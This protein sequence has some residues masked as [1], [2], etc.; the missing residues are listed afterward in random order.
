MAKKYL[1]YD[2][3]SHFW[4]EI[5]G[6]FALVSHTHTKSEITDFPT[7]MTPSSHTH[8]NITNGG[9]L[10]SDVTIATGDKLTIVDSSNSSKIAR[11]SLSFDTA[12]S[13]TDKKALTQAG[14]WQT[15]L[16]SADV[17]E[18]ASA[19]STTPKM[20]GTATVGTET[21][22]ARG[23]HI[24]PTDTSRAASSHT[25]GNITNAGALQTTDVAIANG[26][27]LVVTDASNSNKVARTSVSF[28]GS[29]ATQ[30][31]SK[32]GTWVNVGEANVLEGV[33]IIG[34]DLTIT[35]K[36]VN[37]PRVSFDNDG[38]LPA[39][40]GQTA[41]GNYVLFANVSSGNITASCGVLGVGSSY[42]STGVSINL[43]QDNI[44]TGNLASISSAT[45]SNAGV[46]SATD[47]SKLDSI[48]MTNGVIDSS[49]LPSFVDDVIEAYA[50]SNQTEL[51]STWLATGSA[52]GTAITPETGKIYVLMN[53]ST[54]YSANSQF[55]WG[56]SA[57]VKLSD[58][59]VSSI[60][61]AEIDTILAS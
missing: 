47:K 39:L 45:T 53:D 10:S 42:S 6:L 22:F 48:T 32:A 7:T 33:Q 41:D 11:A 19:S 2:G 51:G 25:H 5:K 8:G 30:A 37:I 9:A 18:G 59:G 26:D 54:S 28:D 20:D 15:F 44:P 29:T 4:S 56:G 57:Y 49:V 21:A 46:M 24:H 35:N 16:T 3:L 17:P 50:R 38:V 61:N 31:L 55:R 27:K 34:T 40:S 52:S 23:D 14:T 58:G 12:T 1:D 13:G 60:T 43:L 36:K